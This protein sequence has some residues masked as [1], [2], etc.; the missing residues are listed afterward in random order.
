[1]RTQEMFL[2]YRGC[3]SNMTNMYQFHF[4]VVSVDEILDFYT[5]VDLSP[6]YKTPRDRT[7]IYLLVHLSFFLPFFPIH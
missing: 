3:Y 2:K 5:E 6:N 7:V 1:M 4:S